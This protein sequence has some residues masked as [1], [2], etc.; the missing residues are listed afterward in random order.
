MYPVYSNVWYCYISHTC[1]VVGY[2]GMGLCNSFV[3]DHMVLCVGG[4]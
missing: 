3:S 2:L 1:I 4:L